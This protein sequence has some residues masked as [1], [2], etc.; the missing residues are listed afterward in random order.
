MKRSEVKAKKKKWYKI[1]LIVLSAIIVIVG[2]WVWYTYNNAKQ[3]V[4]KKMHQ[5]VDT[6]DFKVSKKKVEEKEQL[7]VL[8]LGI[9]SKSGD[10]GRSDT[11]MVMTLRPES[12]SMQ[13]ISITRDT[14]THIVGKGIDD[15]INYSYAFAGE[16][17][18]I[19]T[20]ENFLD[21]DIDYHVRL[22]MNGLK[23]LIDE[24]DGITVTNELEWADDAYEFNKGSVNLD[25][26]KALAY[27]RMRKKD[28]A[29]DFGRAKR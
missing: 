5:S 17:M 3:T 19:A 24:L 7:N 16:E 26:D 22:N 14:R 15:K 4:N 20:V 18:A 11:L 8:I 29:G 1:P 21:I 12:D 27:A 23:E 25:G 10:K 2:S 28:P 13:L 6:I 9:D